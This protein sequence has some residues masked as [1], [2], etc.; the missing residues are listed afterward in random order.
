[1]SFT[2]LTNEEVLSSVLEAGEEFL[3]RIRQYDDFTSTDN[4]DVV[5]ERCRLVSDYKHELGH[6]RLKLEL[7]EQ[8]YRESC[9]AASE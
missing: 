3:C 8:E 2:A 7:V 1:M 6:L 4:Q 5:N 9:H